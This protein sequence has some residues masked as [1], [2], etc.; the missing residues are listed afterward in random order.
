MP[1]SR[2]L[3]LAIAFSIVSLFVFTACS[4]DDD[5]LVIPSEYDGSNFTNN[6]STELQVLTRLKALRDEAYKGRNSDN[7]VSAEAL[8]TLYTSG[9]PSLQSLNTTFYNAR[10]EGDNG[11]L[12]QLALASAKSWTLGDTDS[13]GGTYGGYLFDEN[14]VE[15]EQLIEKGM[16]AAALYNHA[17]NVLAD[18]L[19]GATTDKL[20]AIFGAHPDFANSTNADKHS[21]PD[22]YAASY[23]ARRDKNDGTGFYTEIKRNL[24]KLQAAI[25]AGDDFQR[26]REDAMR[27][28]R[29][30]WEKSNAATVV[31]YLN[32]VI[33]KLSKTNPEAGDIGPALHSLSE[34]I[35][36]ILG[37]KT[38]RAEHKIITESQID[39]VLGYFNYPVDGTPTP[40]LFGTDRENQLTKLQQALTTIQNV[41][42]FSNQQMEDFKSNW[43]SIQNR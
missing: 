36:F 8:N 26:E 31:N 3:T 43:V 7:I 6:A 21:N 17:M 10:I 18:D 39:Q 40:Y 15:L 33:S 24:I 28:F 12:N 30:N 13:E 5:A 42:G 14:G 16:F 2:S 29:Q 37:W 19:N 11:F 4:S 27:E 23:A 9:N 25:K 32:D 20:V 22:R 1:V 38:I 34:S 35:G 41:Y